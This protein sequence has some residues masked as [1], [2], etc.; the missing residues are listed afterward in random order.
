MQFCSVGLQVQ[1]KVAAEKL[2][3]QLDEEQTGK[4]S[5]ERFLSG[6]LA[7]TVLVKTITHTSNL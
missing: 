1:A 7:D 5:E 2:F 6:C 4:I 3:C